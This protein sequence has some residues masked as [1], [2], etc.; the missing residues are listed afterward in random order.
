[1]FA[2][3]SQIL[4][5]FGLDWKIEDAVAAIERAKMDLFD[6]QPGTV[7]SQLYA[8]YQGAL[9]RNG[10]IDFQDML[11]LAVSGM[12]DGSIKPYPLSHLLV[13]E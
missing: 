6:P 2:I 5:E 7:E 11:R 10:K 4:L 13:D 1:R 12:Q 3:V 9:A 8:A